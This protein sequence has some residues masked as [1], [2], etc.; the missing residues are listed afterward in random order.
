MEK[1]FRN[2]K[3]KNIIYEDDA[4]KYINEES[5][6]IDSF[7]N[8]KIDIS[9]FS[10]LKELSGYHD[11]MNNLN[12]VLMLESLMIWGYNKDT[13]DINDLINLRELY[14]RAGNVSDLSFIKDLKSLQKLELSNLTKLTDI[15]ALVYLSKSLNFLEIDGCKKITF[16]DSV[17]KSLKELHVLKIIG[18][19]VDNINWISEMPNLKELVIVNCNIKNGDIS[20]A[21]DIEYVAIDNKRHYNYKFDDTTKKIVP[22]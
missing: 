14:L 16:T 22:K 20:P 17:L 10:N 7:F 2:S 3:Q 19:D 21:K 9:Q 15:S 4:N 18:L 1:E 11:R 12:E 6:Y 13:R 5:I 8:F